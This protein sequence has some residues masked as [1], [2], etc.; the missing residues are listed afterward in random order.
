MNQQ[1]GKHT[2][3]MT[4]RD[5]LKITSVDEVVS[6]DETGVCVSLGDTCM[7]I[8][9]ND[10]SVSSLSLENGEITIRGKIDSIVYQEDTKQRKGLGRFFGL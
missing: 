9:G 1:N 2:L 4:E 6:F 5:Y 3:S 10:L 7:L 8:G